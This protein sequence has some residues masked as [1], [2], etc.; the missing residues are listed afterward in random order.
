MK[1]V[2]NLYGIYIPTLAVLAVTAFVLTTVVE[3]L[4]VRFDFYRFVWHRPL[5]NTA[6]YL[7]ILWINV[8][9]LRRWFL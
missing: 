1:P 3:R 6:M 7:I 8:A 5:F 9:L 4:L 2:I